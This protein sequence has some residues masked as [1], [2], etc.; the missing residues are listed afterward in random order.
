MITDGRFDPDLAKPVTMVGRDFA[1]E[2][3]KSQLYAASLT[4]L[5]YPMASVCS[6]AATLPAKWLSPTMYA[7]VRR[8]RRA[9]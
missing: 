9:P 3:A 8:R 6:R 1:R 2:M 5:P 7:E 4:A